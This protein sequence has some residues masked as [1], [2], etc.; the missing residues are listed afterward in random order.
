MVVL[1]LIFGLARIRG[2]YPAHERRA[3][4]LRSF[5]VFVLYAW[6][7]VAI[8]VLVLGLKLDIVLSLALIVAASV[9]TSRLGVRRLIGALKESLSAQTILMVI[10]VM[11]FKEVLDASGLL[12]QIPLLFDYLHI[13]ST[14]SLFIL[15]FLLGLISGMSLVPVGISFPILQPIIGISGPNVFYAMLAYAGGVS[16][17]L[18]SPLHL[19][20]VVSVSYFKA[21]FFSVWKMVLI[22]V[23]ILDA[24]AFVLVFVHSMY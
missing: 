10:A 11:I 21:R 15:P 7:I 9:L 19:C 24:V 20:L 12:P 1:G 3:G 16:G 17:Y 13:P 6:P 5:S 2:D 22:P 4:F 18:L 14:V 23:A 8:I